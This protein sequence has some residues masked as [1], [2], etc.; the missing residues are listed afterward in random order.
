MT[1]SNVGNIPAVG[2][3]IATLYASQTGDVDGTAVQLAA[4]VAANVALAASGGA[5]NLA[6]RVTVPD[7]L[8]TDADYLLVV[9]VEVDPE[10]ELVEDLDLLD[11]NI[12][13]NDAADTRTFE[14]RFGTYGDRRNVVLTVT[15]PVTDELVQFRMV[16]GGSGRVSYSDG[17]YDIEVDLSLI[18]I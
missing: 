2:G 8:Q 14:M 10:G 3:V 1:V 12:G 7:T 11:N 13:S 16:R 17:A 6:F 4:P 5:A 18:H 15:D 9:E